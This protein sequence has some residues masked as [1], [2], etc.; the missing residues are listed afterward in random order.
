MV[1][2]NYILSKLVYIVV[3]IIISLVV[4]C[5][6]EDPEF[7]SANTDQGNNSLCVNMMCHLLLLDF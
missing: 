5:Q 3:F 4:E 7:L 2:V 6:N 1:F